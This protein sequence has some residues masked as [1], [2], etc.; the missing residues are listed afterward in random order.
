MPLIYNVSIIIQLLYEREPNYVVVVTELFRVLKKCTYPYSPSSNKIFNT[1]DIII[2]NDVLPLNQ[3]YVRFTISKKRHNL[4]KNYISNSIPKFSRVFPSSYN[5]FITQQ[6]VCN[7]ELISN[8]LHNYR[9]N[10]LY[11]ITIAITIKMCSH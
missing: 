9:E 3:Y 11:K 7:Q 1:S 5:R 8:Y 10:T 6:V 4:S 2:H